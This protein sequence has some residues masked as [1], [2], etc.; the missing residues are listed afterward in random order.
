MREV[1]KWKTTKELEKPKTTDE[2][3]KHDKISK[4]K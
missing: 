3:G 4:F 1:S 2:G